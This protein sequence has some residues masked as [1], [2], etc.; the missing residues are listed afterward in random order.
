[1][2]IARTGAVLAQRASKAETLSARL[3]GLLGHASLPEDE[4][5]IFEGCRSIHTVGMRFPI[6]VVF[7]DRSWT[8]IRIM[9]QLPPGRLPMPVW[10]G[11]GVMELS[12]GRAGRAGLQQGDQLILR[13]SVSV[14]KRIDTNV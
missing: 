13:E 3:I 12:S 10:N 11:W 4:A 8:V 2:A 9:A 7:V 1:V 5:L 6:D 14:E